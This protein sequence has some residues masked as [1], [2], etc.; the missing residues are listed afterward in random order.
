MA[1][2]SGS[3][4]VDT[5]DLSHTGSGMALGIYESFK[6]RQEAS[7]YWSDL[8]AAQKASVLVSNA[9]FAEDMAEGIVDYIVANADV[10]IT[11]SDGALQRVSALDTDAP[12]ADRVL[13]GAIE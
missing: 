12:S 9:Q 8:T 3:V 11:T 6:A 1:M 13:N 7:S 10:R 4:T 5:G 2:S